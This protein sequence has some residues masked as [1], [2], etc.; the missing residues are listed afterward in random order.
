MSQTH[1]REAAIFD[2]ALELPPDQRA[3][4]LDH[5]CGGDAALRQ[6][7]ESLL[8]ACE[9]KCEFLD[10]PPDPAAAAPTNVLPVSFE[11]AGTASAATN[12]FGKSA[13]A[14]AV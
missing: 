13:M 2:A 5:A 8:K 10:S 6:R 1:Q 11:K 12:C 4:H 9:S 7:I 14:A 3:A